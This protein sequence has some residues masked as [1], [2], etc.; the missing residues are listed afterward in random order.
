M[1]GLLPTDKKPG[2]TF[3]AM[4]LLHL[5]SKLRDHLI[6]KDFKDC[7]GTLIA[8]YA[9]L[10]YSSRA[11][12]S[13]AIVN[14]K[15]EAAKLPS[16]TCPAFAIKNFHETSARLPFPKNAEAQPPMATGL[17]NASLAAQG[18]ETVRPPGTESSWQQHDLS[19]R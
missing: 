9:D 1:M 17:R 15:Y 10:L 8:E 12:C 7:T 14:P 13:V 16:T 6:T 11:H 18:Q 3:L 19:T 4:F 5:P 2:T